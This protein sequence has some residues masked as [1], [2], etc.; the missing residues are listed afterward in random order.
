MWQASS[1]GPSPAKP[2]R[3]TTERKAF[4]FHI[5][6][7]EAQFKVVTKRANPLEDITTARV[8]LNDL[9]P[10]GLGIF[11]PRPIMV[12]QEI[13]ITLE[14]PRQIY[15][16]GRIVWCMEIDAGSHVI[17]VNQRYSYRLGIQFMFESA[18]EKE[19]VKQFVE[20]VTREQSLSAA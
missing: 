19:A 6:R 13:S 20:Q 7:V 10:T 11:L 2:Q 16:R 17:S 9:T 12:G 5:R 18:T 1:N 15:L 8:I 4:P 14:E 3:R